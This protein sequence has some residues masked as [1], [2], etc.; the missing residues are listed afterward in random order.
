[1]LVNG[2]ALVI[3][4][5]MHPP[6]RP[7]NGLRRLVRLKSKIS[8][9]VIMRLLLV[10]ESF[11]TKHQVVMRLQVFGIDLQNPIEC[12]HSVCVLTLQKQNATVI[13]QSH[14]ISRILRQDLF[15]LVPSASVIS[16]T[17]QDAGVEI[18]R[19]CKIGAERN[20]L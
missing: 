17:A 7:G 3:V 20:R 1:M 5:E 11:V 9:L 2:L 18:M 10:T 15:Q 4:F 14:T 13:V 6:I 19:S 12:L 8:N 16:I